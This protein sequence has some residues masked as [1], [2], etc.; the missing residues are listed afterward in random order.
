MSSIY[1]KECYLTSVYHYNALDVWDSLTVGT[2][3]YFKAEKEDKKAKL[4]FK[5]DVKEDISNNTETNNSGDTNNNYIEVEVGELSEDDSHVIVDVLKQGF[6]DVFS[7]S[8]SYKSDNSENAE[9][10]RRIKVVVRI[11]KK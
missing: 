1:L 9:E 3:L 11:N 4:I 5:K 8:I 10:D 6:V 7:A 2:S